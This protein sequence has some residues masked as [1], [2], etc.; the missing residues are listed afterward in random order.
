MNIR[1]LLTAFYSIYLYILGALLRWTKPGDKVTLLVSFEENAQAVIN[2]YRAHSDS[3]SYDLTVLYTRH[4][5]S[6]KDELS[7]LNSRYF[8]EKIHFIFFMPFLHFLKVS[9]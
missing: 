7:G 8:N 1:S 2:S 9:L 6:L 4:A 3:L 5:V